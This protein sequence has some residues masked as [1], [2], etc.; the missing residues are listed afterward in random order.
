[1][2]YLEDKELPFNSIEQPN[3]ETSIKLADK[4]TLELCT[5]FLLDLQKHYLNKDLKALT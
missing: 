3:K 2:P 4:S 5:D 1:M